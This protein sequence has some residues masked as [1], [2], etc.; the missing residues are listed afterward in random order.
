MRKHIR[1]SS[2]VKDWEA[3]IFAQWA[4]SGCA[5]L[6][7]G[8]CGTAKYLWRWCCCYCFRFCFSMLC[9]SRSGWGGM[10]VCVFRHIE[11]WARGETPLVFWM[12]TRALLVYIKCARAGGNPH[13]YVLLILLGRVWGRCDY[14]QESVYSLINVFRSFV[15][16][17]VGGSSACSLR[18]QRVIEM[19][20]YIIFAQ[21]RTRRR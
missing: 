4:L 3:I 8:I 11:Q 15:N 12:S 1:P 20:I 18:L 19:Y 10:F 17:S 14:C 21:I 5:K 6:I 2:R 16:Q 7:R 9:I 13:I